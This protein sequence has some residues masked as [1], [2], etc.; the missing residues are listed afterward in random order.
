VALG[1]YPHFHHEARTTVAHKDLCQNWFQALVMILPL[2]C[3]QQFTEVAGEVNLKWGITIYVEALI[4]IYI[5][6]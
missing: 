5:K 2:A 1:D 3:S 4:G 6:F